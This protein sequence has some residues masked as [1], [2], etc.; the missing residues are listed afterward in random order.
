[1]KD[2]NKND[3]KAEETF[4]NIKLA[5]DVLSDPVFITFQSKYPLTI[6]FLSE[7]HSYLFN[8]LPLLSFQ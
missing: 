3:A 8:F 4:C 1:L 7:Y 6:T 5:Y 2:K